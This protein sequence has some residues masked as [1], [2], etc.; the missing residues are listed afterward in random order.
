[1]GKGMAIVVS[2]RFAIRAHI[3][4]VGLGGGV[5]VSCAAR[6]ET[7]FKPAIYIR[8]VCYCKRENRMTLQMRLSFYLLELYVFF[9]WV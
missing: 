8:F 3:L 4:L 7:R 1:M 2:Q 6:S 5:V 9:L